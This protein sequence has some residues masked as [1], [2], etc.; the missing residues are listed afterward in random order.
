MDKVQFEN[1]ETL[2]INLK[3]LEFLNSSGISILS[4]FVIGIRKQKTTQLIAKGLK[5]VIWQEKLFSNWSRLM[6][7]LKIE[8]E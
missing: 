2:T 5:G 3:N 4:R 1:K 8:W 7:N 6:P